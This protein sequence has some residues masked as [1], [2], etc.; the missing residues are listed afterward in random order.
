MSPDKNTEDLI[1][2]LLDGSIGKDEFALLEQALLEDPEARRDYFA[3]MSTDQML[4]DNYEMPDHLAMHAQLIAGSDAGR[5]GRS[6]WIWGGVTAAAL[7]L[8]SAT[9]FTFFRSEPLPASVA[10]SADSYFLIDGVTVN[11]GTWLKGQRLEV[12]DGVVVARL[13]PFTEACIDGPSLIVLAENGRDLDLRR[14]R[15]YFRVDPGAPAFKIMA[16]GAKVRHIGTEFGVW[17]AEG[18]S[19]EVHVTDG[20]VEV[21]RGNQKGRWTLKAG[22]SASWR[23]RG[24]TLL[25]PVTATDFRKALPG[26]TVVFEDDFSEASGTLLR[27]KKPD[28]GEPWQVYMERSPTTVGGGRLDTSGSAR[29]LKAT[30]IPETVPNHRQVVLMSFSTRQPAW[31][32]DKQTRLGGIEK[33]ALQA[34]DG[35]VICSV[36]AKASEGHRWRIRDEARSSTGDGS[37]AI[38]S[39]LTDLSA[40]QENELTLR[41]DA[42]GGK[43]TLHD[44]TSTQAKMI[45]EVPASVRAMPTSLVIWNDDG[46]DLALKRISVKVVDYP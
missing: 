7:V 31:I 27:D 28:T 21:D 6:W 32:L 25:N 42:L 39:E 2:D 29:N 11:E 12:R 5:S 34:A 10:G 24:D 20:R 22:E 16:A 18:G 14:G 26:E 44:G 33:I 13:N 23:N 37:R 46:G 17:V 30:F 36:Q 3:L 9:W 4:E 8:L 15:V 45:A 19:C 35:T 43:V 40:L 1:H 41:Y 38:E